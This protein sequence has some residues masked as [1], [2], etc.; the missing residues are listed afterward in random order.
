MNATLT[1][2]AAAGPL[3]AG[4]SLHTLRLHR[5]IEAARRDPLTG[6]LRRD[7]FE[8]RASRLLRQGTTAVVVIDLDGLKALNDT[9]GHAAG[10]AAI[11]A[12]GERLALWAQD[13][14]PAG[15]MGG[16]EFAAVIRRPPAGQP[17]G[18]RALEIHLWYLH[19]QLCEPVTVAGRQVPLG[20]SIGAV[21][22]PRGCAD[23]STWM[24]RADEAMYEA[25]EN[26]GG[27][28]IAHGITP[29]LPT[30]NGRRAGRLG[31]AGRTEAGG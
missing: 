24:R 2:L 7:G 4:W 5:R 17:E 8:P 28:R 10:D 27:W 9:F 11:R 29:A 23:L 15:R 25:K 13:Y 21:V 1:A 22:A 12:A 30:V 26:G 16:D 3:A 31:T 19:A 20:A 18:L 14:G 6:L